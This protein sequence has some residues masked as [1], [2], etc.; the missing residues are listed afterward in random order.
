M[1]HFMVLLQVKLL[2]VVKQANVLVYVIQVPM[3]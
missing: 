2:F 1:L 3:W